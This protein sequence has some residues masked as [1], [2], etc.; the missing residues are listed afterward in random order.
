MFIQ[1]ILGKAADRAALKE[2]FARWATELGPGAG[3]WLGSTAGIAADGTFVATAMFDSA[4]AARRNSER[5]EQGQWWSRTA[6]AFAGEPTFVDCTHCGTVG[7][8]ATPAAGFV[9]VMRGTSTDP[10]RAYRLMAE[11][12]QQMRDFRPDVL[13]AVYGYTDDG[14]TLDVIYFASEA[15]AREGE[16][17]EPPAEATE[18]MAEMGQLSKVDQFIDL[19]EP[20]H[21]APR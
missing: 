8:G 16:R 15:Q 2:S 3:G 6:A 5:P 7:E 19:P 12:E 4:E 10:A 17:K 9:Q 11:S 20:W 13:G 1:F 14:A 18:M 21:L